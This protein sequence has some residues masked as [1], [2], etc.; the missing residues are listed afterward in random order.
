MTNVLTVSGHKRTLLDIGSDTY[1]RSNKSRLDLDNS[2]DV[3][4]DTKNQYFCIYSQKKKI[5][6]N[7]DYCDFSCAT[8][9]PVKSVLVMC[10]GYA[11]TEKGGTRDLRSLF[12]I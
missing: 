8:I 2:R 10:D 7:S 11:T 9:H 5:D 1:P 4:L 6:N 12:I 3:S